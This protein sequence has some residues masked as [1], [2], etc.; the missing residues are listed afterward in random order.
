[1]LTIYWY[2][3]KDMEPRHGNP[4][5]TTY[6]KINQ[7]EQAKL[8]K[9]IQAMLV[10]LGKCEALDP[11]GTAWIFKPYPGNFRKSKG[12]NYS[13]FGIVE[14]LVTQLNDGKDITNSMV[15][16]WDRMF[17]NTAEQGMDWNFQIKARRKAS[18]AETMVLDK[19]RASLFKEKAE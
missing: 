3:K 17:R 14:D 2:E 12:E 1:M 15:G 13:L 18:K 4:W 5:H 10:H 8:I 9:H 16:R 6:Y 7:Q 19:V 11:A